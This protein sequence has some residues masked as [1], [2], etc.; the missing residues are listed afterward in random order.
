MQGAGNERIKHESF[1]TGSRKMKKNIS[2]F[3]L[4]MFSCR[5]QKSKPKPECFYSLTVKTLQVN[6]MLFVYLYRLRK[7]ALY[8]RKE[9]IMPSRN[10]LFVAL[11]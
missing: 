10:H 11:T 2:L 8:I 3:W 4:F 5:Q 6:C 1:L 7:Y 9:I